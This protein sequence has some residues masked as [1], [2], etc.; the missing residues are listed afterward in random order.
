LSRIT[1]RFVSLNPDACVCTCFACSCLWFVPLCA[2]FQVFMSVTTPYAQSDKED[3]DL[4]W[5]NSVFPK[6]G[7]IAQGETFSYKVTITG[8]TFDS[9]FIATMSYTDPPGTPGAAT[10]LVNDLDLSVQVQACENDDCGKSVNESVVRLWGNNVVGGDPDNNMESVTLSL[11]K[12]A[13]VTV[14]VFAKRVV[15]RI[16]RVRD[17]RVHASVDNF[18]RLFVSDLFALAVRPAHRTG[19]D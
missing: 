19:E 13:V 8:A 1:C 10:P 11:S 2:W 16:A 17:H 6:S 3:M 9:P 18:M 15:D 4:D 7:A 5:V 12:S 14:S